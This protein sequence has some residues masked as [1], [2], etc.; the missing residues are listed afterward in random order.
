MPDDAPR[1]QETRPVEKSMSWD[2]WKS[3]TLFIALG[4]LASAT[5]AVT[6]EPGTESAK[7]WLGQA[8]QIEQFIRDARVVNVEEI[9]V[10]VTNPKRAEL[11]PGGLVDRI[12]FKPLRPGRYIGAWGKLLVRDR[13]LRTRQAPRVGDDPPTVEKRVDGDVGAAVMWAAP[14]QSFKE[15]GGPPSPAVDSHRQVELSA[16]PRQDVSQPHLQQGP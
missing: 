15:M 16:H 10:G 9:G 13:G 6:Q 3:T 14:T 2:L 1:H 5:A 4:V 8:E 11:A 12:A 7:T